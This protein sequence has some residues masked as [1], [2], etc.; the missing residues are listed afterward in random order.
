MSPG[1]EIAHA[2]LPVRG[3]GQVHQR[4]ILDERQ[5]LL[6]HHAGVG[7]ARQGIDD[8]T[9]QLHESLFFRG[10]GLRSSL[11]GVGLPCDT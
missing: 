10:E 5:P 9:E 11:S 6:P 2:Q 4:Q 7:R 8:P 3:L 1:G